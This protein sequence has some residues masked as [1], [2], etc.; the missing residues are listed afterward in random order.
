MMALS[1][2]FIG[3]S[4]KAENKADKWLKY[5][6]IIHGAFFPGCF[7]MPMTGV[8]TNMAG[9]SSGGGYLALLIWCI[10]FMPIGI[11]SFIHFGRNDKD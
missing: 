2:F 10:Y 8:F 11:L 9:G 7:I 4:V 1:T 5:L 6:L 3:L